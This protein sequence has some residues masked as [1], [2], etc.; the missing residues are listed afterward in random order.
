MI[1]RTVAMVTAHQC[2]VSCDQIASTGG[3]N[4]VSDHWNDGF[5]YWTFEINIGMVFSI[6]RLLDID[7]QSGNSNHQIADTNPQNDGSSDWT[8]NTDYQ[9][10]I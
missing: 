6:I 7:C 4:G 1:A 10:L 9:W 5:N 3:R 2:G 8:P